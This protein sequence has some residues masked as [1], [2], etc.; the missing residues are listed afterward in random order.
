MDADQNRLPEI[1]VLVR[2]IRFQRYRSYFG[3]GSPFLLSRFAK[4]S[5]PSC[6][7]VADGPV[8]LA[9]KRTGIMS[10]KQA[11][12]HTAPSLGERTEDA[13]SVS[14]EQPREQSH[15]RPRR[16]E[17]LDYL[18]EIGEHGGWNPDALPQVVLPDLMLSRLDGLQVLER[19]RTHPKTELLP[20]VILSSSTEDRES[21]Y[22]CSSINAV[23]RGFVVK[24]YT[25]G[26]NGYVSK[27]GRLSSS[28]RPCISSACT[29]S[30]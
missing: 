20:I 26:A 2:I 30:C 9:R 7:S 3:K 8:S 16:V 6:S 27:A 24:G 22:G 19:V 4:Y 25:L 28:L 18:F 1:A 23:L 13:A 10:R 15:R 21:I 12:S 14:Q 5:S 11:R 17:A 29:A